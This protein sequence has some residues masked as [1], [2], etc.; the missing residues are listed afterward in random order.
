MSSFVGLGGHWWSPLVF[1]AIASKPSIRRSLRGAFVGHVDPEL[2]EYA[3]ATTHQPGAEHAPLA[4]LAG[5]LFT[6]G[7]YDVY[8]SLERP[9]LAI[10]DRDAHAKFDRLEAIARSGGRWT[11]KRI[12]PTRGMPHFDRKD[13]TAAALEAFWREHGGEHR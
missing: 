1:A 6:P 12:S 5:D 3:H 10:Y 2:R 11:L 8:A 9:V 13:E 7:I 4:F